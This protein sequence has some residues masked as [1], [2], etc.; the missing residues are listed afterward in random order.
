M[1]QNDSNPIRIMRVIA[2]MNVGGPAVQ[3]SGL[4]RSFNSIDFDQRLF[5]GFCASDEADYIDTIAS[6]IKAVRIDGF[7]RRVNLSGDLHALFS[8]V[9]EIRKFKPHVIHTHTAKA[10]FLGRIASILSL[11]GSIRVHTFHG[12]LLNGYFGTL[13]RSLVIL[14]EKLLAVTTHQ[15][16]AVGDKVRKDLLTAGVGNPMKFGLMPP[17]LE[18]GPL[19]NKKDALATYSLSR[20]TLHCAYIGR[21]T[22][23]KRPDRFLDVARELKERGVGIEFFM[24]GDGDLLEYCKERIAR[25]DLPVK[26][27]GWQNNIELVLSAADFVVLTSDNEGTPLSLIQAGMAG[28]PVVTTRVGSVPEVVLDGTTGIVTSLS[29]LDIADALEKLAK[30]DD[31]RAR[32]GVAAKEFTLANFGVMRLVNDHEMLYKKLIASRAKS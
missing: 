25:E 30:S 6:D 27:L 12:H 19:L 16:L 31:L 26:I 13:K 3:V 11:H 23:I 24:A 22:K 21:V 7:G 18:I 14:A 15:L 10:G 4:M 29:V 1:S 28:L 17:G 2:R 9:K 20:Q 32:M 8:L 5:T